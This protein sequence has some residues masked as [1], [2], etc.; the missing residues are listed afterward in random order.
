MQFHAP[1]K[2]KHKSI[3][4]SQS[5]CKIYFSASLL[6]NFLYFS[7]NNALHY[8]QNISFKHSSYVF[9]LLGG[10]QLSSRDGLKTYENLTSQAGLYAML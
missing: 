2:R 6:R 10:K 9:R 3:D 5:E 7:K 8:L 4:D 1:R